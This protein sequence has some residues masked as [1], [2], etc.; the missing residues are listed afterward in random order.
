MDSD[1]ARLKDFF[2]YLRF[3]DQL[4]EQ[5]YAGYTLPRRMPSLRNSLY[6]GLFSWFLLIFLVSLKYSEF[7]L[8]AVLV[9]SSSFGP[10]FVVAIL[11]TR[12][13]GDERLAAVLG[14]VANV[15]SGV[16]AV[17]L[18]GVLYPNTALMAV[19]VMVLVFFGHHISRLPYHLAVAASLTYF[20]PAVFLLVDSWNHSAQFDVISALCL[21]GWAF[22]TLGGRHMELLER[23]GFLLQENLSQANRHLIVRSSTDQ[24]TGLCNR[25]SFFEQLELRVWNAQ[26]RRVPFVLAM[27]DLDHFKSIN[28]Q[29]GHP[30]GDVVLRETGDLLSHCFR[31]SDL[32]A[33]YGGEEFIVYIQSP[34]LEPALGALERFRSRVSVHPFPEIGRPVT[35]SI[36][37]T[38]V[39]PDLS[40]DEAVNLAD[41]QL[42]RAKHEG[43][44][45]LRSSAGSTRPSEDS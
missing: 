26:R 38:L 28:D 11:F 8:P 24:L 29:F 5:S 42:Y 36:G 45:C 44:N 15:V 7:L 32:A 25:S 30:A 4:L 19:L 2:F 13:K 34:E 43:R 35:C 23:E 41:G 14:A 1:V 3:A 16:A 12:R 21:P 33:R 20:V 9:S 37:A 18:T 22:A 6:L 17:V 39:Q 10:A 31:G 40:L 27:I